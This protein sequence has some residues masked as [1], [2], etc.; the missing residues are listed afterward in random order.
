MRRALS[1]IGLMGLGVFAFA[2]GASAQSLPPPDVRSTIDENGVNLVTGF[3]QVPTPLVSIGQPSRGGLSYARYYDSAVSDWRDNYAGGI[4]SSGTIYTV[5]LMGEAQ[6]FSGSGGV[7]AELEQRGATL[8][9]DAV[10]NKY[11]YITADGTR[12]V[13]DKG[14]AGTQ[15][16]QANEGRVTS[17]TG[18]AGDRTTFTYVSLTGSGFAAQRLQSVTN[19]FGYQIKF[20]YQSS[21]ADATGLNLVKATAINNAVDFCDPVANGCSGLTQVWPMLTFGTNGAVRTVTDS[22]GRTTQYTLGSGTIGVRRPT[23]AVDN[24]TYTSLPNGLVSGVSNGS[25][26]WTYQVIKSPSTVTT[27]ITAPLGRTRQ[28]VVN[29]GTGT[30]TSDKDGLGRIRSYQYDAY[31]RIVRTTMPEGDYVTYTYDVRG[32]TTETRHV[33]K[34]GSG[35]ADL[36]AT[37]SYPA[38]CANRLTCNQPLWVTDARGFVTDFTYDGTH[39][40]LLTATRPAATTGAVRPQTRFT[41]SAMSANYKQTVGGALQAGPAIY[42]VTSTSICATL[43][44]CAG[45]ADE[46]RANI[47]FGGSNNLLP[48]YAK[49]GSG[50]GVLVATT[51]FTYDTI[52][53]TLT[54]DGPLPGV[55]DTTRVRYDAARQRIGVIGPDPDGAGPLKFRAVRTTYDLDG[56]PVTI[57]QGTVTSQSDPDWALFSSLQQATLTYDSMTRLTKTTL[58]AG[59]TTY[60]VTQYSYDAGN[61]LDCV[62]DRMNPAVFASLPSSACTLGTTGSFG[63]DRI[64][65]QIYDNADYVTQLKTAV[66]TPAQQNAMTATYTQNGRQATYVDANGNL[67]T[68]EYDGFDRAKKIR[69]PSAANGAVSSTT[70]YEESTFDASSNVIQERRRDGAL[71]ANTF[72]RLGRLTLSDAPGVADDVSMTYDLLRR[73]L[74]STRNAQTLTSVYDALNRV[75]S[76]SAPLGATSYQYN[77][78]GDRTRLTYPDGFFIDYDVNLVGDVTAIREN[79]AATGIGVLAN[80]AYD[81]LGRRTVITRGNATASSFTF[82]TGSRLTQMVHDLGGGTVADQNNTFAWNPADQQT[83]RTSSNA[84]YVFQPLPDSTQAYGPNG[85]NQ[86]ATVASLNYTYDGRGN[87]TADGAKTYTYSVDNE[88]VGASIGATLAYDASGRLERTVSGG[89]TT[90]FLYD[91]I[92]IVGEYNGAG[93]LLRR[94]VHGPAVDETVVW[95]EGSGT[96]DRRWLVADERGSV[97]AVTNASGVATAINTYDAFGLPGANNQGRFQYTGQAWLPEVGLYHYKARA[98][99]PGIGR[100]MQSDPIGLAGGSNLYAYVGGDPINWVDPLGLE[101][102]EPWTLVITGVACRNCNP[103]QDFNDVRRAFLE[104]EDPGGAGR[105]ATSEEIVVTA[106]RRCAPS[107]YTVCVN[108][109]PIATGAAEDASWEF[110]SFVAPELKLFGFVDDLFRACGCFVEGTEVATPD[111]LRRIEDLK[112][113]DLVLAYNE[114]T[115]A[116]EAKPITALVRPEPQ[117]TYTL[118]LQRGREAPEVFRVSRDHP[119]LVTGK[120]WVPTTRLQLGDQIDAA[121]GQDLTVRSLA[122][123]SQIE[124][125]YNLEVGGLH[126]FLVGKSEAIVH[127]PAK[128][129]GLVKQLIDHRRKLAD[130][131]RD[132]HAADN[133]GRLAGKT[134]AEQQR[135]ISGRI[136]ELRSQIRNFERQIRDRFNND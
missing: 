120:G 25:V 83:S 40:G 110:F 99:S 53:N 34:A 106:Q 37:A 43:A 85:L 121:E 80:Y 97:V 114:E 35:L 130:Y 86:Y 82:D 122:S 18:P 45:G 23:S 19:S 87:L 124:Q 123:S 59:A 28:I 104:V 9:F 72:D 24:I 4:N 38:S 129:A 3:V 103:L 132:P 109:R 134:A 51:Q 74:T 84:S 7:F 71:I 33:A 11:T 14:V 73:A 54:I 2:N 70:D 68:F 39:G 76:A 65:Q 26:Q 111:G 95:Y 8:T 32:N 55:A 67:T 94:Y 17:I 62:A 79:G 1:Y 115:G 116:T 136:R 22:L 10:T 27:T 30:L 46:I 133:L 81:D 105:P 91:G 66:G 96:A 58:Q 42:R 107:E 16:T 117:A 31:S 52:G 113:G 64:S 108:G 127:N 135:I 88:L 21:N 5:T 69:Y 102:E 6:I 100:F 29:K 57:E 118:T 119:W 93:T 41:Y 90:R 44:T 92:D 61:R 125:T 12:A 63:A 101:D 20:E 60:N 48:V 56:L 126:T 75:T 50:N 112:V 98:Y 78:A 49:A 47:S 36:V 13:F 131:I 15:P 77:L 128:C 89:V